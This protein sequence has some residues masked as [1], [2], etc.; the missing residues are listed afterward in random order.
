ML[1]EPNDQGLNLGVGGP[2]TMVR[3]GG[4]LFHGKTLTRKRATKVVELSS[5]SALKPKAL[6]QVIRSVGYP[7]STVASIARNARS[8]STSAA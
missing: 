7:S 6:S 5:K 2:F 1:F 4:E 8:A 3:K